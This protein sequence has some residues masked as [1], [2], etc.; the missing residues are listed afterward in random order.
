MYHQQP[1]PKGLVMHTVYGDETFNVFICGNGDIPADK[2]IKSLF[3]YMGNSFVNALLFF[4][5]REPLS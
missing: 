3:C 5:K 1:R 4:L 2:Y